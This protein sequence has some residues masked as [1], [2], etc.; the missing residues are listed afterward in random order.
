MGKDPPDGG[1]ICQ[2]FLGSNSGSSSLLE[3]SSMQDAK[4]DVEKGLNPPV[5]K[6]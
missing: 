3:K 6:S 5:S 1:L 4:V 2:G